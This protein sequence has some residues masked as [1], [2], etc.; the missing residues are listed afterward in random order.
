M[1][2]IERER[3]PLDW[4]PAL[5][6][7]LS[8]ANNRYTFL[9]LKHIQKIYF[10]QNPKTK[11]LWIYWNIDIYRENLGVVWHSDYNTTSCNCQ[12]KHIP[13]I[14]GANISFVPNKNMWTLNNNITHWLCS[15]Y[16]HKN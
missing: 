16:I 2:Y 8:H 1:E 7:Y 4:A 9:S 15:K 6:Y 12:C 10:K 3:K 5:W 11:N 13:P 14:G